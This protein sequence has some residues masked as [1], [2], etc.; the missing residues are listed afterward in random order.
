MGQPMFSI[1]GRACCRGGSLDIVAYCIR[2][3]MLIKCLKA[4]Y[5]YIMQPQYAGDA[6]AL[7]TLNNLDSYF[8][9]LKLNGPERWYYTE[10]TKLFL[11]VH[12]Y[13]IKA[14]KLFDAHHGFT[15]FTGAQ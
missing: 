1:V 14:V 9:S 15:V 3:L 13:N 12:P 7:G 11:T 8:N 10:P 4:V 6:G 5:P 2:V